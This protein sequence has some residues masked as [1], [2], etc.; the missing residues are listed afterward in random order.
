MGGAV[1]GPSRLRGWGGVAGMTVACALAACV[2]VL[3]LAQRDTPSQTASTTSY[4]QDAAHARGARAA[5]CE[6]PE[7]SLRPS[8]VSGAAVKRI[9]ER[10]RLIAGVD[11]NSFRWGYRDP[12]TGELAGFDID[13]VRAIAKDILG[14]ADKVTFRTIP[15]NQRIPALEQRKVDVI[16]RTMTINC[17]RIKQVA[18][19]TAY[20]E[21][22]QQVLVPEG[23][24][25]KDFD[26]T[27]R[28]KKVC[29][30]K[31]STGEAELKEESHGARV[32][33]VD[34]QLDCLVRLQL[35]QVDAVITDSALAAGQ[36]AQDP[37]VKL[38]GEP[39]TAEPYGVAMNLKDEDLV[40]RVNKVLDNYRKGGQASP[41]M[42]S[43]RKWLSDDL[44]GIEGPP[45]PKYKP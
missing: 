5:D 6:T 27:L 24:A 29:T 28:G 3:P 40:R 18:F 14:D 20:F 44:K 30:A 2:S 1:S 15:T 32:L 42:K 7:A 16:A 36:A 35:G 31:G 39:F 21:A 34:N 38:V 12:A 17:D 23:S 26:D 37:S 45:E 25:I 8:D 11:Q 9:K 13:L 4:G 22:G 10:G 33:T 41:W 43:Y 19:S